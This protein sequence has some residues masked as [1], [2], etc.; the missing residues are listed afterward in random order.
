MVLWAAN[1][2]SAWQPHLSTY[3]LYL[4]YNGKENGNYYFGVEGLGFRSEISRT[5]FSET[6]KQTADLARASLFENYPCTLLLYH[7]F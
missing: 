4:D 5:P 2:G 7:Q 1:R 6:S 3:G